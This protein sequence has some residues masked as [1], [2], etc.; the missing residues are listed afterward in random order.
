MEQVVLLLRIREG[1]QKEYVKRHTNVWPEVLAEME[2]AGIHSMNIYLSGCQ[3]VVVMHMDDYARSVEL[4]A[5]A[6]ASVQ[7]EEFMAPIMEGVSPERYDPKEA[8]PMALPKV[9]GWKRP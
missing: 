1:F 7:W 8:W 2:A 4:L 5:K 6:P 9:F 3:V